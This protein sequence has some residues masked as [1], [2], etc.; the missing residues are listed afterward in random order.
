MTIYRTTGPLDHW[1]YS[2]GR[3]TLRYYRKILLL[4]TSTLYITPSN[5]CSTSEPKDFVVVSRYDACTLAAHS[6]ESTA[7]TNSWRISLSLS[8]ISVLSSSLTR[9]GCLR[10]ALLTAVEHY[11]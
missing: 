7:D 4:A 10:S 9:D 3:T 1:T 5:V 8:P 11:Q 2:I 6:V